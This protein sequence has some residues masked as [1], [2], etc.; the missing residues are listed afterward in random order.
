MNPGDGDL[1][2]LLKRLHLPTVRR[3]YADYAARAAAESWP[4]RDFL[5]LLISEEVAHRN[6]TRIQRAAAKARFP[7]IKTYESFD[8]LFQSSLKRQKLGPYLG[9]DLVSEG[10]NLI[11]SGPPGRGK[12]HLAVAIGYRA[13]Q[14]GFSA[15][16]VSASALIDE[17]GEASRLGRLREATAAWVEPHVLI[18]DEVGYLNHA[19][20]AANVLFGVVDQRYIAAK[21][22]VFTT[23]KKLCAWGDVLHDHDLA[24]VILDRVLERGQQIILGGRS[25]R[26]RNLDP[27]TLASQGAA[28]PETIRESGNTAEPART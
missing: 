10:R 14:N 7:F 24:E 12:T 8:F 28:D 22:I 1:D 15:G 9:P 11:L 6:D 16:F 27:E 5:A 20:D 23:N 3:L 17:L 19:A 2:A 26:T 13:I 21:P 25:Y 4:H 18:I